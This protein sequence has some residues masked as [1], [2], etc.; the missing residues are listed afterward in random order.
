VERKED[1]VVELEPRQFYLFRR[2]DDLG[3]KS[4]C[5]SKRVCKRP[6]CISEVSIFNSDGKDWLEPYT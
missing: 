5:H 1:I 3:C 2:G 6:A 4:N